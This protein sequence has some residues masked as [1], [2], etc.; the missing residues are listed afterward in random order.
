MA[1][2]RPLR[3]STRVTLFF[4]VT[5]LLGGIALTATTFLFARQSLLDQRE[6]SAV[7][8]AITNA[9]AIKNNLDVTEDPREVDR[10]VREIET[11][12]DGWVILLIDGRAVPSSTNAGNGPADLPEQL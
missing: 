10:S 8:S 1:E 12:P 5:A 3:L 9:R 7:A 11:D 2:R 6:T 4:A